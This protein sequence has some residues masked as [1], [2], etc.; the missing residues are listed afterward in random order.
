MQTERVSQVKGACQNSDNSF[1]S[2]TK[3]WKIFWWKECKVAKQYHAYKDYAS[4][5]NDEILNSFNPELQLEDTQS[6]ITNKLMYLLS[7]KIGFKFVTTL[8][9]ELK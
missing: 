5:Y 9:L 4:T 8:V 6:T 7:E 2:E 1:Y 3:K